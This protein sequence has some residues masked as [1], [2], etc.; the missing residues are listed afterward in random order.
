MFND[1]AFRYAFNERS[2]YVI[3]LETSAG[4]AT[5]R[6]IRITENKRQPLDHSGGINHSVTVPHQPG[7]VF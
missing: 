5:L 6:E 7:A 3:G 2:Q 1:Y 4:S